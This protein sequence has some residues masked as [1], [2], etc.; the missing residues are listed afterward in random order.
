MNEQIVALSDHKI[1]LYLDHV[2]LERRDKIFNNCIDFND[3]NL[4]YW[5]DLDIKTEYKRGFIE[6]STF[7]NNVKIKVH[8]G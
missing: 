6:V 8:K 5:E 7:E 3:L 4:I 1:I 2:I